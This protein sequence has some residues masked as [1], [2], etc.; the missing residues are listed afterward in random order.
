MFLDLNTWLLAMSSI[1]ESRGTISCWVHGMLGA[2]LRGSAYEEV[3]SAVMLWFN[4][5]RRKAWELV[6]PSIIAN[7][8]FKAGFSK[9][10]DIDPEEVISMCTSDVITEEWNELT[11]Q[12]ELSSNITPE[13]YI[14][15]DDSLFTCD[16]V[17]DEMIVDAVKGNDEEESEDEL[18]VLETSSKLP[19][20]IEAVAV[21]EMLLKFVEGQ[22]NVPSRIFK[23]LS[24]LDSFLSFEC[25]E[26]LHQTKICDFFD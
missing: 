17:T 13:D 22:P 6:Q 2:R 5:I 20:R 21:F 24:E 8:F 18:E 14:S 9:N 15:A 7:C 4:D 3:D 23:A 12:M 1:P 26:S 25:T 16:E 19:S 10:T 11:A